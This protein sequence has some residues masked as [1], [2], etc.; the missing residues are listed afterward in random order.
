MKTRVTEFL[1]IRYPIL[2]SGMSWISIPRMVAA[3]SNAGGLG[4][5]AAN[6]MATILGRR[7]GTAKVI[8]DQ[9]F[10]EILGVHMIGPHVTELISEGTALIGL[11]AAAVDLSR[12]IHPHPTV[13]EG[14]M[15]AAHA[16]YSGAAI[17]I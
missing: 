9:R 14:I 16:L 8:S 4:I 1:G 15:E 12:L 7:E 10:G 11:E 13:S 2:L 17:H 6:G 3:V 5:L